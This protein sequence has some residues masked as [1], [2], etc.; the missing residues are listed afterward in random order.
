MNLFFL[1]H[2]PEMLMMS[3]SF[4][5]CCCTIVSVSRVFDVQLR[6]EPDFSELKHLK[7]CLGKGKKGEK[8]GGR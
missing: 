7:S 8:V 3:L 1:L 4:F 6:I 5:P 2:T